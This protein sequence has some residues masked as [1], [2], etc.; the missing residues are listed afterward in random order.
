ME[1]QTE[2]MEKGERRFCKVP[3]Y[4][5]W[6]DVQQQIFYAT[7]LNSDRNRTICISFPINKGS[8][9]PTDSGFFHSH[10]LH[11][12]FKNTWFQLSAQSTNISR[13]ISEICLVCRWNIW[14]CETWMSIFS[15]ES[16]LKKRK[17]KQLPI[18]QPVIRPLW[19]LFFVC[20]QYLIVCHTKNTHVLSYEHG[21]PGAKTSFILD[22]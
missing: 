9:T 12:I 14:K 8:I 18:H 19:S 6:C 17:T 21:I 2:E 15:H 7:Y 22:L 3:I 11:A 16:K 1:S 10:T 4:F 13:I 5:R 20:R